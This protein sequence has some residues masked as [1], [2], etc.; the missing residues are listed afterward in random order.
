MVLTDF[1]ES[2]IY[3]RNREFHLTSS[4]SM[5][6][7]ISSN[8]ERLIYFISGCDDKAT[9]S[10]MQELA[11]K[12]RYTITEQM[13]KELS[14]FAAGY[15]SE[16][17]T[18]R[19]IKR[20]YDETG[21]VIDT[22]TAVASHVADKIRAKLSDHPMII[23]STA[24][25]FKFAGSVVDAIRGRDKD[26]SRDGLSMIDELETLTDMPEPEAVKEIRHAEVKHDGH[27]SISEMKEAV[28]RFL[29]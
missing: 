15:A 23:A 1:F 5:D 26:M 29:D 27:I 16:E 2:G 14:D 8:L 12:G 4:P 13:K 3:D 28:A 17:D 19:E 10:F 21:Y 24:S 22:H 9:S 6:I 7:L 20:V 18:F 25:P 11:D